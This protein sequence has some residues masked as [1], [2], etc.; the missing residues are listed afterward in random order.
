VYH[1]HQP[2]VLR[3][4][5]A[6]GLGVRPTWL[7]ERWTWPPLPDQFDPADPAVLRMLVVGRSRGTELRP[8][9]Q[10]GDRLLMYVL[11]APTPRELDALQAHCERAIRVDVDADPQLSAV[12]R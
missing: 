12:A 1:P 2:G 4:V 3:D 6:D 9:R 8:I 7:P 5:T 10:S 11:D